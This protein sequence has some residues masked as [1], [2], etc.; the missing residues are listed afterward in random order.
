[1]H[2]TNK[3]YIYNETPILQY[4]LKNEYWLSQYQQYSF[5]FKIIIFFSGS[6]KHGRKII[7]KAVFSKAIM[8]KYHS[9]DGLS[10]R[11]LV[12]QISGG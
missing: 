11:N 12:S 9:L 7:L 3:E 5:L 4:K 8:T 10:D 1:M 6:M 2:V